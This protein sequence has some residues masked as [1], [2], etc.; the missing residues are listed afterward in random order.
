[1]DAH[2]PWIAVALVLAATVGIVATYSVFGHT[3]D[4]PFHMACGIEWL[5]GGGYR[6]EAQHP[7]LARVL[8]ALG[9]WFD[10]ARLRGG[11][12]MFDE[13]SVVLYGGMDYDR[14]ITLARL[15]VLPLFWIGALLV[16]TWCERWL[17]RRT[18][19]F[20]ILL[21]A[22]TPS[23]LAHSSLATTDMAFAVFFL[24]A[25]MAMIHLV[26]EPSTGRG[27][28]FGAALAIALLSKFST[29][30][31]F[32]AAAAV[33]AGWAAWNVGIKD[34]GP[35]LRALAV[36][37]GAGV[38][39]CLLIVWLG[40]R[41]SFG[42]SE[43]LGTIVPAP[44]LFDGIE[45]VRRHNAEGHDAFLLGAFTETGFWY[46]Y[47]VTLFFKTPLPLLILAVMGAWIGVRRRA[48]GFWAPLAFAIGV[49]A[50]AATSR[51][52]I[53]TRHVLPVFLF[54]VILA[55]AGASHLIRDGAP[56]WSRWA[57]AALLL[58]QAGSFA[59][60]HPDYLAYTNFLAGSEPEK[61]LVDSDLDWG[62]DMK[63]LGTRLRQLGAAQVALNPFQLGFW[64]EVHGFPKIV[65]LDPAA[66]R[67]GWNAVSVT[68]LQHTR[69]GTRKRNPNQ[70]L[71]TDDARP[72]E[73]VGRGMLL[74]YRRP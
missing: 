53:G 15:G 4:E 59:L 36:P 18:A 29:L 30:P 55:A 57:P 69:M 74:Y 64:E 54:V 20:A 38:V 11:L 33:A 37:L 46:F 21:Y 9:P 42:P 66:P 63:R 10:G 41:F 62:Q 70:R 32:P 45:Q 67:P 43:V 5:S 73:R 26:E 61:I 28:L 47:P 19:L 31:F 48:F 39:V 6:L 65:P 50:F 3:I 25:L 60:T 35:K 22:T 52:N 23:L 8:T 12:S 44:E 13:G 51:I 1:M 24:A 56:F 7:P 14:R 17:D 72:T 27:V 71:W 40:Y 2:A 68:M 16:W 34:W 58:F 49:L